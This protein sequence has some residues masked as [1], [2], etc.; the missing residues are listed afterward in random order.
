MINTDLG[1]VIKKDFFYFCDGVFDTLRYFENMGFALIIVTNQSGIGRG[2]YSKEEFVVLTEW[3]VSKFKSER[4]NILD[5]FYCP[6][7]PGINCE[8]RKPQPGM[9]LNAATKYDLNLNKSWL[10]GDKETDIAA[11]INAGIKNHILLGG[12]NINNSSKAKFQCNRIE[13]TTKYII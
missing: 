5:V 3:M 13:Q 9:I 6:H 7:M 4:V 10:I 11:A 12:D 8:C 2:F 1:Y